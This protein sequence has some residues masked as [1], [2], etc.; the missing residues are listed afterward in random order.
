MKKCR[1]CGKEQNSNIEFCSGECENR[2][3]KII[4]KDSHK[5]KYFI[6]GI[7]LGFFVMI[8]GIGSNSDFIMG[9]GIIIMGIDV[10]VLPFTTPETTAFFG[11]Q[12]SKFIGRILG[13]LLIAVGL[14]VGFINMAG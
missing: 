9:V 4:E 14:W 5:I 3:R 13:I 7:V 2:Y 12:K 1:Y 8:Y 11:Y 6:C 10:V